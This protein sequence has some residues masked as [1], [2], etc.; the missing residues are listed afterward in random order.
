[1]AA[2]PESLIAVEPAG[3]SVYGV[4]QNVYSVI[5]GGTAKTRAFD[6]AIAASAMERSV[7]IESSMSAAS[8]IVRAKQRKMEDM[9]DLLALM[10]QARTSLKVSEPS[11][12]DIGKAAGLKAKAE[13]VKTKYGV[14]IYTWGGTTH[15]SATDDGELS[16]E[17][18]EG[19][20]VVLQSAIDEN[21][22][23][24]QQ[25]MLTLQSWVSKR[26]ESFRSA[27]KALKTVLGTGS[28][29]INNIGG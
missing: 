11:P 28:A 6:M 26:D 9:T 7:S 4:A 25:D 14:D 29:V 23:Q 21:D 13:L 20:L 22:N 19:G 12:G 27:T 18:I 2:G 15:A 24:L 8:D 16:R 1:M 3:V 5:E 10:V 17:G